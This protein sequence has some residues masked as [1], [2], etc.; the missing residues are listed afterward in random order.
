M[1]SVEVNFNPFHLAR[2][3]YQVIGTVTPGG[4]FTPKDPSLVPPGTRKERQKVSSKHRKERGQSGYKFV[5]RARIQTRGGEGGRGCLSYYRFKNGN[6]RPDGGHGGNGGAV[7]VVADRNLQ[8]L[9]LGTHHFRGMDGEN[10]TS[11][12]ANGRGGLNTVIRVPCGVI[13]QRVLHYYE[14]WDERLGEVTIKREYEHKFTMKD[15]EYE[16]HDNHHDDVDYNH[17]DSENN[18]D[19]W[20]YEEQYEGESEEYEKEEIEEPK[21]EMSYGI[22]N[23]GDD[24]LYNTNFL[25]S[26]YNLSQ[27]EPVLTGSARDDYDDMKILA[28]QSVPIEERERVILADLDKPGSYVVVAKGGRGGIGNIADAKYRYSASRVQRASRRARGS[29]GEESYLELELK[30]IA[31]LGET[32]I[33][34]LFI[35]LFT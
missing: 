26:K 17:Y 7:I 4:G 11:N 29:L 25:A 30:M 28:H 14:E 8:T 15:E 6:K 18:Q 27:Y 2:R 13:V 21:P 24:G 9:R 1:N 20:Q 35:L 32:Q 10:G 19:D 23:R 5:D 16:Q 34:R 31:D 33:Y 12:M 22:W 3:N